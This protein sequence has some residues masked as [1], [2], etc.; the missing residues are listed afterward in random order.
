MIKT[1][2]RCSRP[3]VFCKKSVLRNFT[4]ST[5]KH[6]CQ[7]LFFNKVAGLNFEKFL[8]ALFFTKYLR[9][10]L[11]MVPNGRCY[12]TETVILTWYFYLFKLGF[13]TT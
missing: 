2:Y 12:Y 6:L 4:K 3:E 10:L 7:R 8:R 9:W 11:L 5:G 1:W 13:S